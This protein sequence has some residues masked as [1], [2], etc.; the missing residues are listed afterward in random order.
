MTTPKVV[1]Y[2]AVSVDGRLDWLAPD[3]IG[4]YYQMAATVWSPFDAVLTTPDTLN[5]AYDK[6]VG[7]ASSSES[8]PGGSSSSTSNTACTCP[9]GGAASAAAEWRQDDIPSV[10]KR[11]GKCILV[12]MDSRARIRHWDQLKTSPWWSYIVV[13]ASNRTPE[14]YKEFLHRKNIPCIVT[15]ETNVDIRAALIHLNSRFGINNIR[16]D[17][18]GTLNGVLLRCNLV[19]EVAVL[20]AP[21]LVGG[22]THSSIFKASDVT[23]Q[24]QVMDLTLIATT[25]TESGLVFLRYKVKPK[26]S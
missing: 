3:V 5:P 15:G 18:G 22:Q 10:E 6:Q 2:N 19:D 23:Q 26:S 14:E 13:L 11:G 21:T 12:I 24:S 25:P 20:F 16:A 8:S 9:T 1:V 4:P 17:C 7:A